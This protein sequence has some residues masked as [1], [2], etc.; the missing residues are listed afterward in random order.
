M[1]RQDNQSGA[2]SACIIVTEY[3][4]DKRALTVTDLFPLSITMRNLNRLSVNDPAYLGTLITEYGGLEL[5]ISRLKELQEHSDLRSR[6]AFS[7]GLTCLGNLAS[8][9]GP[10]FRVR[11]IQAGL[12]PLLIPI[13]RCA[14]TILRD[15]TA[16]RRSNSEQTQKVSTDSLEEQNQLRRSFQADN[17]HFIIERTRHYFVQNRGSL[18]RTEPNQPCQDI[19][20]YDLLVAITI[21]AY[22]S[23]YEGTRRILHEYAPFYTYIQ[24]LT[25]PTVIPQ[26]RKRAITCMRNAVYNSARNQELRCGSLAC[27]RKTFKYNTKYYCSKCNVV[28]YCR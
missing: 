4:F 8:S 20:I 22:V 24:Q 14:C 25:L 16:R 15:A 23:K 28:K 18:G 3:K 9:G 2:N 12:V 13:L 10:S 19:V 26:L 21:V 11:L 7:N 6:S 5:M 1:V 17:D 27:A